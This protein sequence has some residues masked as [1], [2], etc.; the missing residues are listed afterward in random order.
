MKIT[1]RK[2]NA[3]SEVARIP[4][5]LDRYYTI[6]S[7]EDLV[8][9][10]GYDDT[11]SIVEEI[12]GYDIEHIAWVSAKPK[13]FDQLADQNIDILELVREGNKLFLAYGIRDRVYSVDESDIRRAGI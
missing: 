8:D 11:S 4:A 1:H 5:P 13:Y 9:L 3:A 12:P 2:I 6:I 7:D 10:T